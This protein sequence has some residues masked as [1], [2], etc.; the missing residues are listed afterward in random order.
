M[1]AP[2]TGVPM[3]ASRVRDALTRRSVLA[4][5]SASDAVAMALEGVGVGVAPAVA[6]ALAAVAV[7]MLALLATRRARW[8]AGPAAV[9]ALAALERACEAAGSAPHRN[10]FAA[11]GILAGFVLM[12]LVASALRDPTPPA[13]HDDALAELGGAAVIAAIYTGAALSKLRGAGPDWASGSTLRALVVSQVP[14]GLEDGLLAPI[15]SVVVE[16]PR[17]AA[18]LSICALVIQLGAV[19]MLVGPRARALCGTLLVSFH[20]GVFALTGIG[21]GSAIALVVAWAYPWPRWLGRSDARPSPGRA[22]L[23]FAAVFVVGMAGRALASAHADG[24]PS[25]VAVL[26]F[27]PVQVGDELAPGLRVARIDRS[28]AEA[29]L[30]LVGDGPPAMKLR[31]RV[32]E[33]GRD[34]G[35]FDAGPVDL[36]FDEGDAARLETLRPAGEAL[37]RRVRSVSAEDSAAWFRA[38]AAPAR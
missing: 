17:L 18:L 23:A 33:T 12:D 16:S 28:E 9:I 22:P 38:P 26:A 15:R 5:V 30:W 29:V 31:L 2:D 34:R 14:D 36:L 1:T 35:P 3:R 10:L 24:P 6:G 4:A 7:V 25:T 37:A 19:A 21:Y 11:G 20:L 8:V 32:A 27:G 13:R